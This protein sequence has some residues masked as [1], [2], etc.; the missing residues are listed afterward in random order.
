MLRKLIEE[1][2]GLAEARKRIFVTTDKEKG[3]LKKLAKREK[4]ETF[5]IPNSVGGRYSVLTAVGLLPIAVAG[6]NI[7]KLMEGAK[8]AQEKYNDPALKYNECYQY[9]VAR[10]ILYK[11]E[12]I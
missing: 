3:A 1:K 4:Y 7:D 11:K 10:N 8:I 2:Y 6:I 5:V 9:A 12:T